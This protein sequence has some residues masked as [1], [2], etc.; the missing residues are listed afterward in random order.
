M[1]GCTPQEYHADR[2]QMLSEAIR[3]LKRQ[4]DVKVYLD[5]GN[6]GWIT[7]PQKLAEPLKQ[8]GVA[9][10]DGFSL[11]VSNFQDDE[12]VKSYGRTLSAA[13]G[14]KHFVMDTSRNG[15]GPLAGDRQDAWCNPPGRGLGTP[16]TD[17]TDEPLLD[18]VLWIKRP[19]DSDGPAG[20]ARRRASGG[21]TTRWAWPATRRTRSRRHP[22][23]PT[24]IH[25]ASEDVPSLAVTKSMYQPGGTSAASSRG[26]STVTSPLPGVSR[27]AMERCST[28]VVCVTALGRIRRAEAISSGRSVR[29]VARPSAASCSGPAPSTGR[30]LPP[31]CSAGGVK[32]SMRCSKWPS[33][34]FCSLS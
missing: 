17:R 9:G 15:R 21:R 12:T 25:L 8:A 10:A 3:R 30:V 24:W 1:D 22:F 27:R 31:L 5:A 13:V 33:L 4:P 28:S 7:D 14:G 11:N 29:N 2:Y 26:T 20:A 16:P 34:V 32:I 6:P 23:G 19:G 18:A